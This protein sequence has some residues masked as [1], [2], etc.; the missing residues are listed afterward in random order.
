MIIQKLL[1]RQGEYGQLYYR[2]HGNITVTP[3]GIR[4]GVDGV[5]STDTYFN[6]LSMEKW[7]R[8]CD[9]SGITLHLMFQG[10]FHMKIM[11]ACY[12]EDRLYTDVL[13]EKELNTSAVAVH[14]QYDFGQ[15][16]N[17][18]LYYT[19][20]AKEP[21]SILIDAY[22]E[23]KPARMTD[24][25]IALNIC[26]YKREVYLKRNLELLY[27]EILHNESSQLYGHLKVFITDNGQTLHTEEMSDEHVTVFPNPNVGG[28]GGFARGLTEIA[29]RKEKDKI[30]NVIFMD[31][32]VEIE[33][34]AI[35]RT[36]AMLRMLKQEYHDAFIA[37]AMLR[38]DRKNIQHENGAVWDAGKCHFV[39]RGLDLSV[40]TNVVKNE[41]PMKREYAG[42]WY[43][44]VPA[45]IV[46]NDNLPIPVF[47]HE[48]DVEY[49][50]RNA[51]HVIT[52]NGIA[53]W[54]EAVENKRPSVNEY[55]DLRN[56]LIVNAQYCREFSAKQLKKILRDRLLNALL[57][58]RYKD[59][60]LLY[61]AVEDFCK[62]ADWLLEL[63]AVSYHRKLQS[64][65]H[66][67]ATMSCGQI[68]QE[69]GKLRVK[70]IFHKGVSGQ[71]RWNTI[72]KLITWNGWLLPARKGRKY[73]YMSVHPMSLYRV[74]EAVLYDDRSGQGIVVRKEFSQI[75]VMLKLYWKVCRLIDK[76]YEAGKESYRNRYAQ[77]RSIEYWG[78]VFWTENG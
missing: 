73:F 2:S 41:L 39:N 27:R 31:D 49:S 19:L 52:M 22:Y 16:H 75:F 8:Y 66:S 20:E 54:H 33:P 51:N 7:C 64:M 12:I 57:R 43:C 9:I 78:K 46:R 29:S 76:K 37:G 47:I 21:E 59:M 65:G 26:T 1:V 23:A 40:F 34:E 30:T 42:W 28:A 11:H 17:G 53:V 50:L 56:M 38:L 67:F 10:N 45:D 14:E 13:I 74:K 6:S 68:E 15:V 62:G 63:D 72:K 58:Y 3:D 69:T 35:L 25:V 24:V 55:Y 77:L 48:D 36:Y 4:F 70:D 32:D 44:C 71:A 5:I 60:H 18:F 61:Q